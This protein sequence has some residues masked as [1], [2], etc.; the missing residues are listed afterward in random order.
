MQLTCDLCGNQLDMMADGAICPNCGMTYGKERLAEKQRQTGSTAKKAVSAA[1]TSSKR[2]SAAAIKKEQKRMK[3]MWTLLA[4]IGLVV[5]FGALFSDGVLVFAVSL[6]AL[7]IVLFT[8]KPWNVYG[9]K[10]I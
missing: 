5:F 6:V 7:L 4:L 3:T 9:G 1:T 2:R 10:G 8:F